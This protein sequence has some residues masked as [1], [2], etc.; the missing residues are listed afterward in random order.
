VKPREEWFRL[1]EAL[2]NDTITPEEHEQLQ[3]TLK[4][5][6]EARRFYREYLDVQAGL[7]QPMVADA[8]PTAAE[9]RVVDFPVT[10][11]GGWLMF[12]AALLMIGFFISRLS[13]HPLQRVML[14]PPVNKVVQ[15]PPEFV[16]TRSIDVEWAH[17]HRF[18]A[19]V[20]RSIAEKQLRLKSGIVEVT[21]RS[22]AVV[23][24]EG[25]AKL[26]LDSP[27]KC[28][29]SYGK[30]AANCPPSA[31][32]FTVR[33]KG[34]K[35]VD[36]GTEFALDTV[37]EGKTKVHV[38]SGEVIVAV[39]DDRDNV[40][41]EQNLKGNA[42]VELNPET[43]AIAAID[44]DAAPYR[45]MN[46]EALIRSQPLKLQFDLGHRAGLYHGT[47]SPAHAA[48]D[49][50]AHESVWTQI[51]GDQTGA[52]VMAD[53]NICPHPIRV[54]Y[55]HGDGMIDWDA[56]PV[57]PSGSVFSKAEPFFNTALCQDHRP[58][59]FDLGLRVSGLPAGTYRF[60]ALCRSIRRPTAAYDVSFGVNL[61][62]QLEQ[63]QELPPM[64]HLQGVRW[65]AGLTY[66]VS[67]VSVAGPADWATFITR[68]NR[69]RTIPTTKHHGRSVLLGVQVVELRTS[70]NSSV[71]KIN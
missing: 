50:F 66:A 57:D 67:D 20:G 70:A 45:K 39:T 62:R 28:F 59:D 32:G 29:S 41:T 68:Y 2:C 58:W 33:F 21:F 56:K 6:A 52:S 61:D 26:R 25:P 4:E 47:N 38:L 36:L 65:E 49:M 51:I 3:A 14:E 31:H 23:S 60:Y 71:A 7:E 44:Y 17:P 15:P 13:D 19:S 22:G 12:A 53:G 37:A 64:K 46:R 30:L 34:G 1:C 11:I 54:D 40:L 35:V 42:A 10:G 43:E 18:Q 27:M 8:V 24:V 48:G 5:S 9:D 63:S 69:E 16:L 55:G